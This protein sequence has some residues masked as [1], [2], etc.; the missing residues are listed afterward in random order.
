MLPLVE[1]ERLRRGGLSLSA[2][3]LVAGLYQIRGDHEIQL[4]IFQLQ[5]KVPTNVLKNGIQ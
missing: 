5:T 2:A 3:A 1:S 4:G